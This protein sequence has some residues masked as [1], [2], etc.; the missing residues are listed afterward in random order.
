MDFT[1]A[2]RLGRMWHSTSPLQ[3]LYLLIFASF[4]GCSP[5]A[6][7]DQAHDPPSAHPV[8]TDHD[9]LQTSDLAK[10][11]GSLPVESPDSTGFKVRLAKTE[12]LLETEQIDAAW[13]MA[14]ELIVEQPDSPN[15]VFV[16]ARILA[17]RN[18]LAAAIQMLSKID[19][20][21]PDAGPAATGQLAE[22]LAQSG[23]LS[24][25]ELKLQGLLKRFPGS[26][27]AIRLIIDIYHAQ[28]RRWEAARYLD[29]LVR[30][31]NF[32]TP[33]LMNSIDY[34]DPI[35]QPVLR[36]AAKKYAPDDPFVRFSDL[37]LLIGG[38]RW[39]D[40]VEPLKQLTSQYPNLLE[41][42]IWYG[43]AILETDRLDELIAWSSQRPEGYAKHP[44]YWYIYGR[45]QAR[46]GN[47]DF[48][49]GCFLEAIQL[50][51]RHVAA[52]Q[53]LAQCTMELGH[54]DIALEIREQA[55]KWVR[56][57]D[58]ALQI[59]RGQGKREEYVEIANLYRELKDEVGAFGWDSIVLVNEQQPIPDELKQVQQVLRTTGKYENELLDR[60]AALDL[61][62]LSETQEDELFWTTIA[63]ISTSETDSDPNF[64]PILLRDRAAELGLTAAYDNGAKPGRGW[65]T[66]EG[67]GGGVSV[68]DFDRDG[69]PDLFYAQAGD[70]ALKADAKYLPTQLYRSMASHG[71]NE[72]AAQ[73]RVADLGFGQGVGVAD[74]DQDGF[75]DLLLA[76]IGG[77]RWYLNL[78][79]GTFEEMPL[80]QASRPAHWNSSIQAADLNGDT[81][82]DIVQCAYIH[83]NDVY[84]RTCPTTQNSNLLF[85][86]PK[87]F[88]SG[89]SRILYSDG[90]GGW[91]V[92]PARLLESLVDGYALGSLITDLDGRG[93]N[94]VFI[95]N[96][97]SPNHLLLAQR[98]SV[99]YEF[100]E[101]ATS[102]GVAVDALGRAQ[103]S[104]GIACGDQNRDG[105]LDLIVTN[106]RYEDSTLY[107]QTSPGVFIDGTRA[108]RLGVATSEWLSFGC[109]LSDLDNDGWL[110]FVT[111]N[112][113]IDHLDPWKMPPQVLRNE[114]GKF[115]WLRKPSPGAYFDVDNV[116]RSLT[117]IDFNRDG[118]M[119]SVVTHLDRPTALLANESQRQG[120]HFIQL[121]LVGTTSERD[122]IGAMVRLGSGR[123][124]WIAPVSVGDGFYGTN[125][126]LVH[127]GLGRID[128]VEW[129]EIV[130]P[131][132]R[133]ERFEDLD[134]DARYHVVESIGLDRMDL[135]ER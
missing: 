112:G 24:E 134:C 82:P 22:W 133:T 39:N 95:A 42:W 104:M 117:L 29:R 127:V 90:Q 15:V 63:S 125:E 48:A 102:A 59:Q 129:M 83:G 111:V 23:Q 16:A 21:D 31:G 96:D 128:K 110:D 72:I 54:L 44:E 89:K 18:N 51:R 116:G 121:E 131:S 80:P 101:C 74:L 41:P 108:S 99:G 33:D 26:A 25:A 53:A 46:A 64:L 87:R 92:A 120:N 105:L 119:D 118:R 123:E 45:L 62:M 28:G 132:G 7:S 71:F 30:I 66:T 114:R 107:L 35:D 73:A 70:A 52:M 91:T 19:P 68:L 85:C 113:H 84:S 1:V 106:F 100:N 3:F 60:V 10:D 115:R 103:A 122:A 130:W 75:S 8:H 47:I 50:D 97:V 79:D 6:A 69:W 93:G 40:C 58:L 78:G 38:N 27:P 2:N 126:R 4:C 36:E 13:E 65:M 94:D 124:R 49:A 61:P 57:K 5:P 135:V 9:H 76:H 11:S 34:R 109:Q 67:L 37:R 17:R 32:N 20:N 43:E 12:S 56:I 98:T 86:H 88:E 55:G 14:K 81:Y 77:I